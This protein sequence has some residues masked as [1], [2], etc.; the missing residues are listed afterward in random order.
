VRVA[1]TGL[2]TYPDVT[3][4]CDQVELDTADPKR[5]T[6]PNPK[7]VVEVLSPSTEDYDRGDK[8]G[9]YKQI[10]SLE[11]VMLGTRSA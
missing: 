10:P 1:A 11:E 7:V 5:H 8:L 2:G 6:V 4:I 9:N 3:V